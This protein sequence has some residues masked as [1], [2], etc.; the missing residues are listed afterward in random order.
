MMVEMTVEAES[1][2]ACRT[3]HTILSCISKVKVKSILISDVQIDG[4]G[5]NAAS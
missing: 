1:R 3:G 2:T 5:I 4:Y